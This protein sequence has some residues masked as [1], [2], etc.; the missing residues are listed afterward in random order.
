MSSLNNVPWDS[1]IGTV[2]SEIA[3]LHRPRP[4]E[5]LWVQNDIEDIISI[6]GQR[7][8][9]TGYFLFATVV[10]LFE[11]IIRTID[12]TQV[13]DRGIY[14]FVDILAL[15]IQGV[16]SSVFILF[17]ATLAYGYEVSVNGPY[18]N[19]AMDLP[20]GREAAEEFLDSHYYDKGFFIPDTHEHYLNRTGDFHPYAL[21]AMCD[22]IDF[23]DEEAL[24]VYL[25]SDKLDISWKSKALQHALAN[26][27][28]RMVNFILANV[29]LKGKVDDSLIC[30]AQED[31]VNNSLEILMK[32]GGNPNAVHKDL[33][34]DALSHAIFVPFIEA[35]LDADIPK[36]KWWPAV[37]LL[38]NSGAELRESDIDGLSEAIRVNEDRMSDVEAVNNPLHLIRENSRVDNY[39]NNKFIFDIYTY[40]YQYQFKKTL[41]DLT[42]GI[43]ARFR[44]NIEKLD[45][46]RKC[47]KAL[48]AVVAN[49]KE[50]LKAKQPF[51]DK[52]A[53]KI[54]RFMTESQCTARKG[55]KVPLTM[56]ITGMNRATSFNLS[57]EIA[58][59]LH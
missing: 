35:N 34:S 39:V 18:V 41:D 46:L 54:F 6:I 15:V 51:I 43:N 2:M 56:L 4:T 14:H 52:E 44:T 20:R 1:N 11:W 58:K 28:L 37:Q 50:L 45:D 36:E 55:E 19:P 22:A 29:D 13:Y 42:F 57:R 5:S 10:D 48:K 27:P 59:F 32:A 26:N 8:F 16:S 49:K 23:E 31:V 21:T 38:L 47:L 33:N 12:L 40:A 30:A 9:Y 7:I 53:K 3:L 17:G 24:G 25:R